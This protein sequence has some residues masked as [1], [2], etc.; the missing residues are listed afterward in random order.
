MSHTLRS[1]EDALERGRA[2]LKAGMKRLTRVYRQSRS[3]HFLHLG[4]FVLAAFFVVFFFA[5]LR[6]GAHWLGM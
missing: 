1:Q 4:L 5:K 3:W 6:R 2:A